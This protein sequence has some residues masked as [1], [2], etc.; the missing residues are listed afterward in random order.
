MISY[1]QL[2]TQMMDAILAGDP[3]TAPE[4]LHDKPNFPA[5]AQLAVY[6]SGYR[7]RLHEVIE[8]TYPALLFAIG[9]QRFRTLADGFITASPS[10]DF[11]IDKYTIGFAAYAATHSD[12]ELA[13]DLA[14]LEGAIHAVYQAQETAPVNAQWLQEQGPEALAHIPLLPRAASQ[15]LALSMPADAYLTAFREEKAP[16]IPELNNNWLIVLRHNHQVKRLPL[17]EAEYSLLSLLAKGLPLEAALEDARMAPYLEHD[18][19]ASSLSA[20]VARW[21]A[22]GILRQ[23]Q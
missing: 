19:F 13:R 22:E 2:L 7:L 15:L 6:T 23:P 16:A 4:F 1:A 21:V 3:A 20:W 11:N 9:A 10:R 14:L 8:S 17:E 5:P 12:D 18:D